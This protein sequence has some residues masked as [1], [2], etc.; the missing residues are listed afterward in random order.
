MMQERGVDVDHSTIYRW[1][2]TYSPKFSKRI[3]NYKSFTHHSWLV[4]ET[5]IKVNG[6]WKY[7]Y[8]CIDSKGTTLDFMHSHKRDV[9][10]AKRFLRRF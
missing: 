8:R 3:N 10:A 5:Y 1:V 6:K 7:L 9:D 2:F 4:D